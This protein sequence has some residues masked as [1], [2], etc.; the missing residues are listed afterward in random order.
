MLHLSASTTRSIN[1][2]RVLHRVL[3]LFDALQARGINKIR[4][5]LTPEQRHL[6]TSQGSCVFVTLAAARRVPVHRWPRST[7]FPATH[8]IAPSP[9]N[10]FVCY[11]LFVCYARGGGARAAGGASGGGMP[12]NIIY[13]TAPCPPHP[14]W[15]HLT[16]KCVRKALKKD[17]LQKCWR[18]RPAE[19]GP[20]SLPA[21]VKNFL[22]RCARRPC[23]PN[24]P[25]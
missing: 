5:S 20:S 23:F 25:H 1:E 3:R 12:R 15:Y 24:F 11:A 19:R 16:L 13:C 6:T 7:K 17:E 18:L 22:A 14:L 2:H 10:P 4:D 21:N 8:E 9:S